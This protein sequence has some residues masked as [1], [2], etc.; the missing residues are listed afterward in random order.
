MLAAIP[1][2]TL[3]DLGVDQCGIV[4]FTVEG[5]DPYALAARL[6]AR[7]I[8]ISVSTID[9]ARFDF[10][11]RDLDRGRARV[12][13]LLQ[14]RDELARFVASGHRR[15]RRTRDRG[16]SPA[17]PPPRP[18]RH[19]RRPSGRGQHS[20]PPAWRRPRGSPARSCAAA[21]SRR[22]AGGRSRSPTGAR[23]T[24][25]CRAGRRRRR[26]PM[27]ARSALTSAS[28]GTAGT[29]ERPR[30]ARA[31]RRRR[32][33][34][35]RRR[36][37]HPGGRWWPRARAPTTRSS[38]CTTCTGGAAPRTRS[39]GRPSSTRAGSR[40]APGPD[41]R[42]GAQGRGDHAPGGRGATRRAAA[43]P[44]RPAPPERTSGS[45]AAA[46]SSVSGT[47][48]FG[49]RAVHGG[50]RHAHD[51]LG[52]HCGGRVEHLARA[53][54]VHA[55]HQRLVGDRIDDAGEVHDHVDALEQRLPGACP[56][57]RR[58]GT[59]EPGRRR[60]LPH[61]EPDDPR[62][63]GMVGQYLA[64][65]GCPTRPAAPVTAIEDTSID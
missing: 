13:P 53:L 63:V 50:A 34:R 5:V 26:A 40:S 18:P 61:V 24:A 28:S 27:C 10:A 20:L 59:R 7:H 2:L 45:G 47:G 36:C 8:N 65:S 11:A 37:T 54:D 38:T 17:S 3:H 25:R 22:R 52:A 43:R 21:P 51:P 15:E 44:R 39:G 62:H 12:S 30:A 42:R 19:R 6:R 16:R 41:D 29:V 64:A 56:R 60:G 57:C 55:R 35:R 4:T 32:A 46:T 14:H 1:R 31:P 33:S 58:G 48:L 9:F 49:P 23:G